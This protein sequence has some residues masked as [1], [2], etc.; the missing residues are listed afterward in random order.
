V[1]Q[2]LANYDP[3]AH[4]QYLIA[5][6]LLAITI[7][8]FWRAQDHGFVWDDGVNVERNPYLKPVTMSN[9]AR[10]WRGP[11]EN[12]YVPLTYTAWS[13]IAYFAQRPSDKDGEVELDPRWFHTANVI[14]HGLSALAVFALLRRLVANDWAAGA[15]A[16]QFAFHPIQV[17]PVAWITGLKDLLSGLL[18]LVAIWQ[19]LA[20]A[21]AGATSAHMGSQSSGIPLNSRRSLHYGLA[22]LAFVLALLAK[23]AAVVV[24]L[25]A[26]VLDYCLLRRSLKQSATSLGLWI[27][28]AIPFVIMTKWQQPDELLTVV[29]PLWQRPL[30][31]AD[32]LAFYF[33]KL[34]VPLWLGPG[35]ARSPDVIF[36]EGW[37]YF[38]WVIPLGVAVGIWCL[39]HREPWSVAAAGLFIAG[40][41]P[42]LGIVQFQFQ[43]W[44]TVAD[45]YLYLSMLGPALALAWFVS[46]QWSKRK[47]VAMACATVLLSLA[48]KSAFQ[49]E[50]WHNSE[51]LWRYALDIG[52]DSAVV[53][54]NLGA[55]IVEA[56]LDEAIYQLRQAVELAPAYADAHYNL[57]VALA[58]R[59]EFAEAVDQYRTVLKLKPSYPN[60]HYFLAIALAGSGQFDEAISHYRQSLN[61]NPNDAMAH[62]NL[63]NLLADRGL[64]DD[65]I[66]QYREAVR[67]KPNYTGAYFNLGLAFEDRGDLDE[68]ARQYRKALQLDPN[69]ANAHNNL[70]V[71]LQRQGQ[72]E[73]AITQF[74]EALRIRPDFPEAR[75]GLARL[76]SESGKEKAAGN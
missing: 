51:T 38:T 5:I 27:L 58:K 26:W 7:A 42:V 74:R 12:L 67:I 2:K 59:G 70:A 56:K 39:K 23:P 10:F 62:N 11:F 43:N 71:L 17:E 15:G 19:Y 52:Q 76:L 73:A 65:A 35:Y 6:L 66:E 44:S 41:L 29:T 47:W 54:S 1:P 22:T 60:V 40:L 28:V 18:S 25:M 36:E 30:V 46:R 8:V 33:F 45:R 75:R 13:A 50:I 55:T 34:F 49:T 72:R 37:A 14:I 53:R 20:F 69:N 21:A 68:A 16:M 48:I 31:A 61:I 24:P 4:R 63:G 64:L 9:V 32:A 3:K 57:G